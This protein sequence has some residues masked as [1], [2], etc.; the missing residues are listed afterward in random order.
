MLCRALGR[1][2]LLAKTKEVAVAGKYELF[3]SSSQS[4]STAKLPDCWAATLPAL[5]SLRRQAPRMSASPRISTQC[6]CASLII[7]IGL[8]I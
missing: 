1:T 3:K 6:L 4:D 5:R 2:Q 7:L 8:G